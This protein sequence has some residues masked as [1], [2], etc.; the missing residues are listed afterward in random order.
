MPSATRQSIG[1]RL[2]RRWWPILLAVPLGAAA[3][4]GYAMTAETG[5]TAH[6][7]VVVVPQSST[8]DPAS[9]VNL[10]RV[11]GRLVTQ[12]QVVHAAAVEIG[13][14]TSLLSQEVTG[15]AAADA[16]VIEVRGTAGTP[17]KAAGAANAVARSLIV[18]ANAETRATRVR[19]VSLAAAASPDRPSSPLPALDVAVGAAAG[20][21]LGSLTLTLRRSAGGAAS[22]AAVPVPRPENGPAA[23]AEPARSEQVPLD[24]AP[25]AARRHA[26]KTAEQPARRSPAKTAE[27]APA[28]AAARSAGASSATGP[29]AGAAPEGEPSGT[30]QPAGQEP[31]AAPRTRSSARSSRSKE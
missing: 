2:A 19:L 12:P 3:G 25:P 22:S 17:Q 4:G 27:K 15:G 14:R 13:A 21:L 31:T 11:F 18:F 26:R 9:A 30:E 16:P 7:Y 8:A 23:P 5:W 1:R 28:R 10:A 29:T 24:P 6:A 20:L